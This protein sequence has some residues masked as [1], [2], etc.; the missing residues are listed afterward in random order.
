MGLKP[1][2][3]ADEVAARLRKNNPRLR[4]DQ[5]DWLA[6]RWARPDPQGQ[7]V[8]QGHPAHKIIN[9]QLYRVDEAQEV[10]ARI[11]APTL[12]VVA[13]DDSLGK[14]WK[15]SYTLDMF[16]ERMKAVPQLS[17]ARVEDAGHMLHHDQPQAVAGLIEG[18]LS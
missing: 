7:W 4:Q 10:F 16:I 9:A 2:A 6:R 1:Y 15:G 3:G 12:C 5:A 8:I 14:W 17:H 11:T 13:S 18:F